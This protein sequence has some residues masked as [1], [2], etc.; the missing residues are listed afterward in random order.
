MGGSERGVTLHRRVRPPPRGLW[1]RQPAP[2]PLQCR[3]D[4]RV[5]PWALRRALPQV[6]RALAASPPPRSSP[7]SP[8]TAPSR[9]PHPGGAH[10]SGDDDECPS[11]E[12]CYGPLPR[13]TRRLCG[14]S[15]AA[16]A[17][18]CVRECVRGDDC[19]AGEGCWD[20]GA[21]SCAEVTL[22]EARRDAPNPY[23]YYCGA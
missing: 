8:V 15:A 9:P 10:P 20:V 1:L 17:A 2:L 14:D 12:R 22:A 6:R 5:L 23:R 21:A 16:A 7:L 13:C 18:E 19:D 11:G 4:R 3:R